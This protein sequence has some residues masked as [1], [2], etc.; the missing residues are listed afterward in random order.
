MMGGIDLAVHSAK[1]LPTFLPDAI[2]IAGY[3]PRRGRARRLDLARRALA[4][5]AVG[6]GYRRHRL[7]AARR[8]AAAHATPTSRSR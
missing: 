6:G 4:A 5:R 3:L 7:A 8:H 2:T 1:D